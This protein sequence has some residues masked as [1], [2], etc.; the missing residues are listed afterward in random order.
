MAMR[1]SDSAGAALAISTDEHYSHTMRLMLSIVKTLEEESGH[2]LIKQSF[3][4]CPLMLQSTLEFVSTY[5]L[6]YRHV[7]AVVASANF[8]F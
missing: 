4:Q 1:H 3:N 7:S 6:K 2:V 5:L 8:S